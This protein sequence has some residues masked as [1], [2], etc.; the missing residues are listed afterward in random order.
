MTVLR[1]RF[2]RGDRG[3]STI[4]AVGGVVL[5]AITLVCIVQAAWF[6][7]AVGAAGQ[8][9]R[10]GARARSLSL[11]VR[12]AVDRSLPGD[13]EGRITYPAPDTVRVQLDV[14]RVSMFPPITVA[15][16]VAMPRTGR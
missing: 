16:E 8:A 14:R 13:L 12:A 3:T 11:D 6:A 15:R 10:D 1:R 7:I 5:I 4:E 9:A 2:S